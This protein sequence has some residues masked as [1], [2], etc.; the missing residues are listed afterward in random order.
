MLGDIEF[1]PAFSLRADGPRVSDFT[2]L[3]QFS[4][5]GNVS[6]NAWPCLQEL[7]CMLE[8]GRMLCTLEW[9]ML[10]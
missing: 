2:S 9:A 10:M 7:L 4:H 5:E 3:S 6:D 8:T 1:G